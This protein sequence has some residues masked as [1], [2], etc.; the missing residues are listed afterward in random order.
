MHAV[1]PFSHNQGGFFS[2]LLNAISATALVRC[3]PLL[4]FFTAWAA[5]ICVISHNVHNLGIQSTLLT[6]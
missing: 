1:D 6:V 5:A 2:Q 3:W 4:V